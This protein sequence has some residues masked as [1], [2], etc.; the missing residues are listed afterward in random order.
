MAGQLDAVAS[1][2]AALPDDAAVVP[3][4][5]L[6][7]RMIELVRLRAMLDATLVEH[8]AVFDARA[9][10]RYDGAASTQAWLR[11]RLRLGGGQG[12]QLLLAA[13]NLAGLP[14]VGKAFAAGEISLEHATAVTWLV[15]EVGAEAVADYEPILVDLARQAPPRSLQKAC[16]HVRQLLAHAADSEPDGAAADQQRRR[17]LS[18]ARTLAGMV[19][20]QGLLDPVAGDVVLTALQAA[21]P[22]PSEQDGRSATQRRADALVDVCADW[23]ASGR[24]PASGGVQPQVQVTVSL[25]A[26]ARQAPALVRDQPA[27]Q[28]PGGG[29]SGRQPDLGPGGGLSGGQPKSEPWGWLLGDVPVLADGQPITAG[30]ARRMACDAGIMPVVLGSNSEPLDVG[31]ATRVVPAGLRRALRLRDG[32]C[33]FAGCDRPAAWCDA[34]HLVHW[35]DG[36]PTTLDNMILMCRFHHT[37]LHEGWRLHGCVNATIRFQRP[38]GTWLH[39]TSPPRP[40]VR[41]P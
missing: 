38:D 22:V 39:L 13:R 11:A 14:L 34:H 5:V 35:A 1:A 2:V 27:G 20:V 41:G 21:M 8:L 9:A 23:L 6:A 37:L 32:G 15:A 28:P 36:G 10:G 7:S 16:A 3:D 25:R 24:P 29:L 12:G 33:R 4:A 40:L 31:R 17:F 19:H 18:V 26:L 30:Q